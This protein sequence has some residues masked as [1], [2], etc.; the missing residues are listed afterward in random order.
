MG[1]GREFSHFLAP[2]DSILGVNALFTSEPEFYASIPLP[3]FTMMYSK[4][5]WGA[6]SSRQ[7]LKEADSTIVGMIHTRNRR[8]AH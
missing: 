2:L 3:L 5:L 1:W 8:V 7:Q 6:H 4:V